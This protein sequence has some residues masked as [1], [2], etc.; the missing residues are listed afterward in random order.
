MRKFLLPTVAAAALA[1]VALDANPAKAQVIITSGYS[2]PG[3]YGGYSPYYYSGSGI[4]IGNG[5]IGL[6]MYPAYSSFGSP[7]YGYSPY[8]GGYNSYYG[9]G[10]RSNYGYGYSGYSGGYRGGY[11][12]GWRR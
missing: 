12:G 8:Y 7:S 1:F 3:Y 10:Y 2:S 4:A 11:R 5:G 6:G 9:T